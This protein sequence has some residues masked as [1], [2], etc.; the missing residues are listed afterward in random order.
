MEEAFKD[1]WQLFGREMA[2]FG[3][4]WAV[5]GVAVLGF[6]GFFGRRYRS[7]RR[8]NRSMQ[9][10]LGTLEEEVKDI[11]DRPSSSPVTIHMPNSEQ[12]GASLFQRTASPSAQELAP[13]PETWFSRAEADA[14]IRQSSLVRVPVESTPAPQGQIIG[15]VVLAALSGERTSRETKADELARSLMFDFETECP[16]GVRDGQYGKE[17]LEWWIDKKSATRS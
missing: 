14:V 16:Q 6:G 17:L 7:M 3:L 2:E 12:R 11:R 1:L 8:D 5:V 13:T 4:R 9:E 10:R 15:D